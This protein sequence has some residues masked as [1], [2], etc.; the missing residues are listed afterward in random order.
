MGVPTIITEN[1]STKHSFGQQNQRYINRM[2]DSSIY[3]KMTE[4]ENNLNIFNVSFIYTK[5][6]LY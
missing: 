2:T 6:F 1:N 5:I 4:A 3:F